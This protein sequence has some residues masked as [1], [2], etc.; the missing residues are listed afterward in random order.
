MIHE[1]DE[2]LALEKVIGQ[3]EPRSSADLAG[4]CQCGNL[5]VSGAGKEYAEAPEV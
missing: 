1:S 4:S 5:V 3:N 2:R